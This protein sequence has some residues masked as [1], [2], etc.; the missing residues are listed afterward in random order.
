MIKN[1][2]KTC[3]ENKNRETENIFFFKARNTK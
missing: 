1:K 2:I 3:S